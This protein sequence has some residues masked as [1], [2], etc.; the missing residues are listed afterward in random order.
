ML[1]MLDKNY[2]QW[3]LKDMPNCVLHIFLGLLEESSI[4]K[5]TKATVK[6]KTLY[7]SCIDTGWCVNVSDLLL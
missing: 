1:P 6:A 4:E 7:K 5:D 2:S 3:I